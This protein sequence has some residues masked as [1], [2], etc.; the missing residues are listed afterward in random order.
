S[1][2]IL[3]MIER[4]QRL[5]QVLPHGLAIASRQLISH[6]SFKGSSD[7]GMAGRDGKHARQRYNES[8]PSPN[9]GP[10]PQRSRLKLILG[11]REL[12]NWE[13]D[14]VQGSSGR[15]VIFQET[16]Q[17]RWMKGNHLF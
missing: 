15:Q 7:E 6:S 12:S 9:Q 8:V 10:A 14:L 2:E 17:F 1:I 4:G 5:D 13:G 3:L 11:E 16:G